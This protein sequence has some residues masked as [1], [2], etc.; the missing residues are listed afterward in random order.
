[1]D[2]MT[3]MPSRRA[4]WTIGFS[5]VGAACLA[6]FVWGHG[7]LFAQLLTALGSID[8][9]L[10]I[11]GLACSALSI[12]NR[13]VLNRCAH[14]AVGLDARVP[15]M[16]STAAVGF[17]AQKMIRSAGAAGLAVFVRRGRRRGYATATVAAACLLT[18]IASFAALGVLLAT[19][20]VVLAATGGLTGWW[21]AAAV[22]F[23]LYS[24]VAGA[25]LW[26]MLRS[27]GAAMWM[28]DRA[29]AVRRRFRRGPA[30]TDEQPVPVVLLD[31]LRAARHQPASMGRLLVQAVTS[32]LLGAAMLA[33]AVA[34][35]GL[36]IDVTMA[37]VVY[38]TALAASM[39]SIVP[40]GVGT[41]EGSTTALL[42]A[43]GATAGA[44]AVAVALFRLFD[45]LVPVAVGALAARREL[46]GRPEI[47]DRSEAAPGDVPPAVASAVAAAA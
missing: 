19:T 3:F 16:T 4:L 21:I 28:W 12:V 45:L 35:V 1:M 17:A 33:T 46:A 39:V 23:G 42:V 36:P 9:V 37:L 26:L 41:V 22:G 14:R 5:I 31:A 34:A 13:G 2:R 38:S 20:I 6:V 15:E 44:S 8:R 32:K 29:Q 47:E 27:D 25:V 43:A 11:V 24:V 7:D 18:A 10:L 30:A 40:G